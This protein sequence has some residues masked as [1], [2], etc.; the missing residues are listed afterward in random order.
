MEDLLLYPRIFNGFTVV[1][2][3]LRRVN[4]P[5]VIVLS[6][7]GKGLPRG[8]AA[9]LDDGPQERRHGSISS[10]LRGSQSAAT[11]LGG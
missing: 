4:Y 11:S 2:G 5:V 9:D 3:G 10:G 7:S 1:W 8:M 6:Q